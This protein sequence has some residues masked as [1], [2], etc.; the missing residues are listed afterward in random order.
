MV[1]LPRRGTRLKTSCTPATTAVKLASDSGVPSRRPTGPYDNN[2]RHGSRRHRNRQLRRWQETRR[3]AAYPGLPHPHRRPRRDQREDPTWP[4]WRYLRWTIR[5]APAKALRMSWSR[6]SLMAGCTECS[7]VSASCFS[8]EAWMRSW[9]RRK[10]PAACPPAPAETQGKRFS[11][12]SKRGPGAITAL[13]PSPRCRAPQRQ[14]G[15]P[16]RRPWSITQ[17]ESN[18]HR[19]VASRPGGRHNSSGPN[20]KA[21]EARPVCPHWPPLPSHLRRGI[22]AIAREPAQSR[23]SLPAPYS[24]TP[25][26]PVPAQNPPRS[27]PPPAHSPCRPG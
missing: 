26:A 18:P 14:T 4:G 9:T 12:S 23:E 24:V 27:Q 15:Y 17:G 11:I 5:A 20:C 3:H 21:Q 22:A 16:W 1:A 19:G 6:A 8:T 25:Y 7:P 13:H 10:S 2:S